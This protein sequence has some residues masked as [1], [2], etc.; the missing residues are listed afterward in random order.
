ML[1]YQDSPRTIEMNLGSSKNFTT[2]SSRV[3]RAAIAAALALLG[4]ALLIPG[5]CRSPR[6]TKDA[7]RKLMTNTSGTTSTGNDPL[8]IHRRAIVIDMHAHTPQRPVCE[9]ADVAPA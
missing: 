3:R 5:G 7:K 4:G 8:A 9:H 1:D 2:E 6:E